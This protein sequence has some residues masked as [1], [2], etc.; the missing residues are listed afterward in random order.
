MIVRLYSEVEESESFIEI[1]EEET[2]KLE[3]LI[4]EYQDICEEEPIGIHD[5]L[6]EK[7]FKFE[8]KT[9]ERFLI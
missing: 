1:D 6:K 9:I 3:E 2:E 5:F 8:Q 4:N 7:G